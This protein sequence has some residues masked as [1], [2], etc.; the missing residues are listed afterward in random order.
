MSI[1]LLTR[2][3]L[4]LQEPT[5]SRRACETAI[6][7]SRAPA[8]PQTGRAADELNDLIGRKE[9]EMG[10]RHKHKHNSRHHTHAVK[11]S[12]IHR[13]L[14]PALP[15]IPGTNASAKSPVDTGVVSASHSASVQL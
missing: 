7:P 5:V 14:P 1:V 8:H 12:G 3:S 11:P 4:S 15:E 2:G 10:H 9:N 6:L 13:P